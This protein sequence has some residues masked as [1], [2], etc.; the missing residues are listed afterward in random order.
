MDKSAFRDE[1]YKFCNHTL[2]VS[3]DRILLSCYDTA[4][5]Y[6][7][8]HHGEVQQTHGRSSID[9]HQVDI[10][11]T[12]ESGKFMYV[13]AVLARPR[14]CQVDAEGSV[15][16]AD[17]LN[18][19]IQVMRADGTWNVLDLAAEYYIGAVLCDMALYVALDSKVLRVSTI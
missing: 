11:G 15:L 3:A 14:L 7:L 10:I 19:R 9:C 17:P 18:D 5:L 8:N 6:T 4:K 13:P 1:R 2:H 16:V 12:R